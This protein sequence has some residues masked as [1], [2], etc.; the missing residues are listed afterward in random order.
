MAQRLTDK[1]VRDLPAP[2]SGNKV[3][4]DADLPGFGCRVTAAGARAFVLNYRHAGRER[5]ITIGAAPA[6]TV[7]TARKRAEELRRAVD[8]GQDPMALR[9]AEHAAPTMVDLAAEYLK[10]LGN[11]AAPAHRAR[12]KGDAGDRDPADARQAP[13]RRSGP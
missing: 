11:P 12:R 9:H 3:Y 13:R 4:Y 2:A 10:V 7:A 5:R 8:S 6:W 1:T